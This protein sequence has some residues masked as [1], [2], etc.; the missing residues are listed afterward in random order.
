[1]SSTTPEP[2]AEQKAIVDAYLRRLN[3]VINAYAGSGKT[4]ILKMLAEA[5]PRLRFLYVAYNKTAQLDARAKFP[6]NTRAYTSHGLA[7]QPMITMARRVGKGQKYL[8]SFELAR[9]MK[10]SQPTRLSD[11]RVL[12]P[13][14]LATLVKQTI[15]R[16]CYSADPRITGRHVPYDVERF[17]PEEL[18]VLC[19][20]IPPI[21]NRIWERDITTDCGLIPMEHDYYLK[22]F[23]LSHPR[24]PGDV[25]ALDEAQDSNPCVAAMITEQALYGTQVIMVGDTY[26]AIYEWRG[27]VDAMASFAR[28][29]GVTVLSLTQSFRFG[30]EI[31][32]EANKWLTLLGAPHPLRGYAKIQSR[33]GKIAL[34]FPD[35][36]LCRTNAEALKRAIAEIGKGRKVA[37]PKGTGELMALTRGAKDLKLGR[38]SEHPDLMA[39]TTWAQLQDYVDTESDGEDLKRF[40]ELVDEHGVDELFEILAQIGSE[41]RGSDADIT[42]STAHSAKGRE[43]RM[44]EIA[45]DFREPKRD[46]EKPDQ[47]PRIP[48]ELAKLAYVAVTRGMH[49]LDNAGLAWVDNYLPGALKAVA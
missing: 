22:A 12:A 33:V 31:A 13:G 3:L 40:V 8:R 28:E 29:P 26:Q 2:T 24:L 34:D 18:D 1:V 19:Q 30:E 45:C 46:P 44:V 38:P 21:A 49:V 41:E 16:F 17:T 23:A 35:A 39:F 42:I 11:Q 36:V 15:R 27:A 20:V 4:T 37:F 25:I 7:F 10:I 43:W 14:Q 9:L 48:P 5:S 47:L 6:V 32:R